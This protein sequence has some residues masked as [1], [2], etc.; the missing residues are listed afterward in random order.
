M[1][2]YMMNEILLD[3]SQKC[4][5]WLKTHPGSAGRQKIAAHLEELLTDQDAINHLVP[6]T[7]GERDLLYCWELNSQALLEFLIPVVVTISGFSTPKV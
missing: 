4:R 1:G 7:A 5:T 2:D 3:L 6:L